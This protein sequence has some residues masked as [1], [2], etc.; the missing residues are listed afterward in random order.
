MIKIS[1]PSP[2]NNARKYNALRIA[3]G[4]GMHQAY[5]VIQLNQHIEI[6]STEYAEFL[7]HSGFDV[8]EIG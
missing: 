2:N 8:E 5:N 6:E 3:L 7:R 4:L 1:N